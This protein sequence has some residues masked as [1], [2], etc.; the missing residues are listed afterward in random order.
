MVYPHAVQVQQSGQREHEHKERNHGRDDLKRDR[1][2]VR[3]QVM[4]LE[5]VEDRP[6]Q[7]PRPQPELEAVPERASRT[8]GWR[9][10]RCHPPRVHQWRC[11]VISCRM[12]CAG[13][14]HDRAPP[15]SG[16]VVAIAVAWG[17]SCGRSSGPI[18]TE[19][20]GGLQGGHRLGRVTTFWARSD[21]GRG[22]GSEAQPAPWAANVAHGSRSRL[23]LPGQAVP[24]HWAYAVHCGVVFPLVGELEAHAVTSETGHTQNV[25]AL[26]ATI[27]LSRVKVG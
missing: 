23:V 5:T 18:E 13:R 26:G 8:A 19:V 17:S 21:V 20:E 6:G 9:P 24:T 15:G 12:R 2:R 22:G 25:S 4:L 16:Y 1:A 11:C 14:G 3:Q 10:R 7:L 27:G